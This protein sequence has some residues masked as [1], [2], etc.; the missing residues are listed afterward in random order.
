MDLSL[1]PLP[2]YQTLVTKTRT[3]V[4]GGGVGVY[5]RTGLPF[6]LCNT[7]SVFFEKLYE[8]LFITLALKTGKKIQFT[9]LTPNTQLSLPPNNSLNSTTPS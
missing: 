7:K 6:T 8:C 1:F 3:H 5:V 4:Q 9:D 2:G